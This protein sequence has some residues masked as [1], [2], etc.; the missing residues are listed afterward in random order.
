MCDMYCENG[1]ALS[2]DGCP[3]CKC[4][5]SRCVP[6]SKKRDDCNECSCDETYNWA[7]TEMACEPETKPP[8]PEPSPETCKVEF[9]SAFGWFAKP[10]DESLYAVADSPR[11]GVCTEEV[12]QLISTGSWDT[13]KAHLIDAV[14][15][16]DCSEECLNFVKRAA[17]ACQ[18]IT[19]SYEGMTGTFK[20]EEIIDA[21]KTVCGIKDDDTITSAAH[22]TGAGLALFA[23]LLL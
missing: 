3:V 20:A 8:L 17:S 4:D 7:C 12:A 19:L 22:V 18:A 15:R 13:N 23:A 1:F 21:A 16:I 2:D 10:A 11:V 6:G 14:Q 5:V 9:E